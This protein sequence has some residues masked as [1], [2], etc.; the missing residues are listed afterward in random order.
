[1]TRSIVYSLPRTEHQ[2]RRV[3]CPLP[4][5]PRHV[6]AGT[7]VYSCMGCGPT[8]CGRHQDPGIFYVSQSYNIRR[9]PPGAGGK[10]ATGRPSSWSGSFPKHDATSK[11]CAVRCWPAACN[12]RVLTT[13]TA[14]SFPDS[15]P[16][17]WVPGSMS[18]RGNRA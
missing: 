18:H 4:D 16:H 14:N 11:L 17:S 9:A 7:T 13:P 2:V 8:D 1:M 6:F 5:M 3:A 15:I 10:K 12:P